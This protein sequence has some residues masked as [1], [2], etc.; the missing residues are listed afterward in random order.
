LL[1]G[2][3][4]AR[5]WSS[6]SG[7]TIE[8]DC[9]FRYFFGRLSQ[10]SD[11]PGRHFVAITDPDTVLARTGAE[12]G[13]RH[14]ELAPSDVGG[15]YSA[16]S[17]F[18]LLP[19]ALIGADAGGMLERASEIAGACGPGVP[20]D[21]N[22]GLRLGAALGELAL[23]GRDK[24]TIL[25]SPSLASFPAWL[26]QLVAE[27]TGKQ[28]KGIVPIVDEP[29]P[30]GAGGA[31]YGDDR[32]LVEIGLAGEPPARPGLAA[33]LESRGHP[34][35]RMTL[36]EPADLGAEIFRWEIATAAACAVLAVH[37]FDQ[38]DVELAKKLAREAIASGVAQGDAAGEIDAGDP[39]SVDRALAALGPKAPGDYLCLQAYLAPGA[40][41]TAR[42]QAARAA[43][44]DRTGL[45]TTLGYGPRFLH[46]TGQLN[47]GG[48]NTAV[49]VQ[50]VD[51]PAG[52]LPIP[53]AP[54]TF[55][56]LIRAQGLGDLGALRQR[57]RRVIRLRQVK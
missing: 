24:L 37:P 56:G 27:S 48:P 41:T 43:L 30:D 46:S 54:Y 52:D 42:L 5:R 17:A 31:G 21:A 19:A 12:R 45:P 3:K 39:A 1:L 28:G 50:I 44:G 4:V 9:L 34:V 15:R 6:K 47:K 10:V 13:F 57:G 38:P 16:L 51:E 7:T 23:A 22:P 49:C 26:E 20:E 53:E 36:E 11:R 25:A 18:G 32:V 40:E 55:A 35:I 14:V 33:S 2:A 29:A 8:T